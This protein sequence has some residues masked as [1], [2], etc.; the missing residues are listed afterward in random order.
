[1]AKRASLYIFEGVLVC[2]CIYNS[3]N[4]VL[5]LLTQSP[6]PGY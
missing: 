3:V 6:V 2:V 4:Y 5:L 1:M